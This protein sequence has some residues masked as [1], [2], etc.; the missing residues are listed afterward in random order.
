MEGRGIGPKVTRRALDEARSR[1]LAVLPFCRFVHR[2]IE[3]HREY[4]DLVPE[5]CREAFGL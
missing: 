3:R 4:A 1:G 2:Y 5:P